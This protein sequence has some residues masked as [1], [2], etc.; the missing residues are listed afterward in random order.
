MRLHCA[1]PALRGFPAAGLSGKSQGRFT[2]ALR[3]PLRIKIHYIWCSSAKSTLIIVAWESPRKRYLMHKKAF[4][5]APRNQRSTGP[6]RGHPRTHPPRIHCFV[7]NCSGQVLHLG[8]IDLPNGENAPVRKRTFD[9]GSCG[10]TVHPRWR[11]LATSACGAGGR[12]ASAKH[13]VRRLCEAH[14]AEESVGHRRRP[15]DA[16]CRCAHRSPAR[17]CRARRGRWA[18]TGWRD[19]P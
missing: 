5:K 19:N 10:G 16:A 15:P 9:A 12:S 3:I 1:I 17:T 8:R 14:A 13:G 11:A 2:G 4:G 7:H 6:I 18:A